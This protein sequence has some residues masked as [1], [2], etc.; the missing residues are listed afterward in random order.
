MALVL[1]SGPAAEPVTVSEAKAHLRIDHNA[2]DVLIASLVL[3]SRL[4]IEAALDIAL[5]R[6]GWRLHLDRWPPGAV[7]PV[8]IAPLIAVGA[9]RVLGAD[10]V[11]SAVPPLSY[12][13]DTTSRQPRIIRVG[14][15]WPVPGQTVN[16]IEIDLVA[17]FGD[18]AQDVPQP[19]RQ[20]LLL[21]VAHWYEHRDPIEIGSEATVIPNGVSE[22]LAPW[23]RKRL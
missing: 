10:G 19:I 9:I 6:Q 13:A 11:P 7:V 21:L 18:T 23:R 8:P 17:G 3:T 1:T 4:H 14:T 20:A 2:E 15:S 5:I 16:G 12:A 22:L